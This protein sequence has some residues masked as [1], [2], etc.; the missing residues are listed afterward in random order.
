MAIKT[1]LLMSFK[2]D[3]DKQ[4]SL[5]VDDPR[6]DLTEQEIIDTMNLI[7]SKNIFAFN[8]SNLA[9]ALDAKIVKT[10]TT[11]YDLEV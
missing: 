11:E 2:T 10:D 6:T 8:G 4:V 1:K 7:L 9:V 3:A 5:S